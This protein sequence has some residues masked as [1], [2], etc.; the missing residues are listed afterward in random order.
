[1]PHVS[2]IV[3]I[4]NTE[5]LIPKCLNSILGQ[6]MPDIEVICVDDC[7]SDSSA[8]VV[9]SFA[10]TDSRIRLIRHST[11]L[12]CGGARN[13]GIQSARGEYVAF[14]D[15]D[16]YV[17]PSFLE[18]LYQAT[19]SG[20]IDIAACGYRVYDDNGLTEWDFSPEDKV[21]DNLVKKSMMWGVTPPH[22]CDKIWRKSLFADNGILF[23]TNSYWEDVSTTPMLLYYAKNIRCGRQILYHYFNRSGSI[24]NTGGKKHLI[25]LL[26]AIDG[27]KDFMIEKGLYQAEAKEFTRFYEDLFEFHARKLRKNGMAN[28][29]DTK[30]FLRLISLIKQGY[31]NLDD[32]LRGSAGMDSAKLTG[33][34]SG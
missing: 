12:G 13:S 8:Q 14:V 34:N 23:P 16:D 31:S 27:I 20:R 21:V 15:S 11:N 7:S 4:F 10:R 22:F 28:E 5:R 30:K 1:M 24:T 32:G 29:K 18:F 3:P 26:L 6:S 25:D 2:V 19:D 17:D 33:Q 9:R